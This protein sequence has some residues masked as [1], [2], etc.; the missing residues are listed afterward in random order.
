MLDSLPHQPFATP[1]PS[2]PK[3]TA[4]LDPTPAP[5][6]PPGA[7]RGDAQPRRGGL[8]GGRRPASPRQLHPRRLS[9]KSFPHSRHRAR[10]RRDDIVGAARVSCLSHEGGRGCSAGGPWPRL[11]L[12]D[13]SLPGPGEGSRGLAEGGRG[14][15]RSARPA[16]SRSSSD[17]GRAEAG[18]R[19]GRLQPPPFPAPS[20]PPPAAVHHLPAPPCPPPRAL[21]P[22]RS[23]ALRHDEQMSAS[24]GMKFKFHSGEKVLCFEPDPTKARVLYDAKVPPRR[25]REEARVGD[26]GTGCGCGCGCGWRRGEGEAAGPG[27]SLPV[28]PGPARHRSEGRGR[29]RAPRWGIGAGMLPLPASVHGTAHARS[30]SSRL[31]C[32]EV[33]A[34]RQL[35]YVLPGGQSVQEAAHGMAP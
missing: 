27:C 23:L 5:G 32:R 17:S 3:T 2:R 11:A 35:V 22:P 28:T 26:P 34:V 10:A 15:G 33:F 18:P 19:A 21:L 1:Q 30:E 14:W 16:I 8:E 6:L 25:D 9:P 13:R 20:L 4:H 24:E 29:S 12:P 7:R 31:R